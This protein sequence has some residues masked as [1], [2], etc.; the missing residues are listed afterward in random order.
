[1]ISAGHIKARLAGFVH[2]MAVLDCVL[3]NGGISLMAVFLA[4]EA[5]SASHLV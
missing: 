1:M 2:L 4:D 3:G 5:V